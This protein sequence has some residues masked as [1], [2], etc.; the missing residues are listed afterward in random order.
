MYSNNI[1]RLPK[2]N[3]NLLVLKVFHFRFFF[4]A[5]YSGKNYDVK[6]R[7][8]EN[9]ISDLE[10]NN[11]IFVLR[12]ILCMICVVLTFV[13]IPKKIEKECVFGYQTSNLYNNI[14]PRIIVVRIDRNRVLLW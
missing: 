5:Q 3:N 12:N 7:K 11:I 1:Y 14:F 9:L 8:K 4:W 6:E 10:D 2:K 13:H